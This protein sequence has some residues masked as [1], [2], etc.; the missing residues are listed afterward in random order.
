MNTPVYII[1][2]MCKDME[3]DVFLSVLRKLLSRA[4]VDDHYLNFALITG[5]EKLKIY[6]EPVDILSDDSTDKEQEIR[7][8]MLL[9]FWCVKNFPSLA[10]KLLGERWFPREG[11]KVLFQNGL[12]MPD[13][14]I[15]SFIFPSLALSVMELVVSESTLEKIKH[16]VRVPPYIRSADEPIEI[17][18]KVRMFRIK[19]EF[20]ENCWRS[21][22]CGKYSE[23]SFLLNF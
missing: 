22:K 9:G 21:L 19:D 4:R 3:H 12:V 2:P 20:V 11:R 15:H 18:K 23:V 1:L 13:E 17:S 14:D 6:I 10:K 5:M 7:R 16:F 8:T